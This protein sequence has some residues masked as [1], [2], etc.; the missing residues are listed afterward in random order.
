M[1]REFDAIENKNEQV[2]IVSG[3]SIIAILKNK[4]TISSDFGIQV[5]RGSTKKEKLRVLK[6]FTKKMKKMILQETQTIFSKMKRAPTGFFFE[7]I[8]ITDMCY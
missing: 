5:Y 4:A 2:N 1:L 7:F 3:S 6:N 8:Q